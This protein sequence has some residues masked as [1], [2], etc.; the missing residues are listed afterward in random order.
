MFFI[1]NDNYHIAEN[2]VKTDS[3]VHFVYTEYPT[4]VGIYIFVIAFA[5]FLEWRK[6]RQ[7][8]LLQAIWVGPIFS[9]IFLWP[10]WVVLGHLIN[11]YSS[12][13]WY[14]GIPAMGTTLFLAGILILWYDK[15]KHWKL[16]KVIS[17]VFISGI[18][19]IF[20]QTHKT[21]IAKQYLGINQWKITLQEQQK[22]HEQLINK[23]GP[24][25][26]NGNLLVYL[27]ITKDNVNLRR[28]N[29][30]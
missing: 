17:I 1:A 7:N 13:H 3:I 18:I 4:I 19:L 14:F 10:T 23:L 5:A 26:G 6:D 24:A 29:E 8:N 11:D 22:L 12:T 16:F 15:I 21:A 9:A 25:A 27:D 20:Y 28:T 30:Y 2:I